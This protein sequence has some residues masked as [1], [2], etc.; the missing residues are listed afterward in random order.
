MV[1]RFIVKL[2]NGVIA[3]KILFGVKFYGNFCSAIFVL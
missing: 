2:L 3:F 1:N